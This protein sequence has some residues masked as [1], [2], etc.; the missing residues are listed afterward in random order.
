MLLESVSVWS[1]SLGEASGWDGKI[2]GAAATAI[3]A[4][5]KNNHDQKL[6]HNWYLDVTRNILPKI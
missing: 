6:F 2:P 5:L 4:K 1:D 3:S